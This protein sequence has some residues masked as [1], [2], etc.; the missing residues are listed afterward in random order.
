[1]TAGKMKNS[2]IAVNV[3]T[4]EDIRYISDQRPACQIIALAKDE[5]IYRKL[6]M[7]H[8]ANPIL[9]KGGITQAIK[10]IKKDFKGAGKV[11]YVDFHGHG[12]TRGA[13][14]VY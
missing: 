1:M 7:F 13:I 10:A 9:A 11:V 5:A 8:G 14:Q 3:E 12:K 2:V 6:A 4:Q